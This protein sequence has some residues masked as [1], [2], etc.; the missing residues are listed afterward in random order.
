MLQRKQY[1][2][3]QTNFVK[4]IGLDQTNFQCPKLCPL[5]DFFGVLP[6]RYV[7]QTYC[8]IKFYIAPFYPGSVSVGECYY[9][10]SN[11]RQISFC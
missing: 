6:G 11:E 10:N 3:R 7:C 5:G 9:F 2:D 1:L 8:A 4:L